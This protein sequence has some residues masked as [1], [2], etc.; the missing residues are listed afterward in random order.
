MESYIEYLTDTNKSIDLEMNKYLEGGSLLEIDG[1]FPQFYECI[2]NS[3]QKYT[4]NSDTD[5]EKARSKTNINKN[6]LSNVLDNRRK[7]PF[8]S[9]EKNTNIVNRIDV[10]DNDED[11]NLLETLGVNSDSIL[12]NNLEG[13]NTENNY[14]ESSVELPNNLSILSNKNILES[15]EMSL[16]NNLVE[17]NNLDITDIFVKKENLEEH[18]NQPSQIDVVDV[19]ADSDTQLPSNIEIHSINNV[20]VQEPDLKRLV[21]S[22][23]SAS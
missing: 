17:E 16:N 5:R 9:V 13:G 15:K 6:S 10:D 8:I 11:E 20:Q 4:D 22:V 12:Q 7:T 21:I 14:L 3:E 2:S 1:G 18:L 23:L 19:N